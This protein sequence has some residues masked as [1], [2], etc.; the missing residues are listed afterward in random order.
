MYRADLDGADG[1][2]PDGRLSFL[3]NP[4]IVRLC[5]A[6]PWKGTSSRF[7]VDEAVQRR[8]RELGLTIGTGEDMAWA[9]D[10]TALSF[11]GSLKSVRSA[12]WSLSTLHLGR[13]R[14]TA[15]SDECRADRKSPFRKT[16]RIAYVAPSA[17]R[18]PLVV[19]ARCLR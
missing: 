6:R 10:G 13:H 19:C 15:S 18:A 7:S 1:W 9:P 14:R 4:P 17:H 3:S 8:F 5:G 2:H 11:L 12:G 16:A